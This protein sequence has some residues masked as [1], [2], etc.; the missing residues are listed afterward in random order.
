MIVAPKCKFKNFSKEERQFVL[1]I[2][3]HYTLELPELVSQFG[4]DSTEETF[5]KL[6]DKGL[7]KIVEKEIDGELNYS[8]AVYDFIKFRYNVFGT[9]EAI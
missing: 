4:F 2:I 7:I 8:L 3:R 1:A 9:D 6:I 5:I